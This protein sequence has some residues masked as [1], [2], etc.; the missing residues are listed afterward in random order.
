MGSVR[1]LVGVRALRT[2]ALTGASLMALTLAAAAQ[3]ATA[4]LEELSVEGSGRGAGA[5]GGPPA[6]RGAD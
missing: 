4:R 1:T 3:Q 6:Q 2:M 5:T